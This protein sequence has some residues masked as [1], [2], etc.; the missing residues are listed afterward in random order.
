MNENLFTSCIYTIRHKD[1]L[2]A[3]YASGGTGEFSER[4]CWAKGSRILQEAR[5]NKQRVPVLFA[6][7]DAEIIDGVIYWALIDDSTLTTDDTTV[8]YS[9]LQ[10]LP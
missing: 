10:P 1:F 9:S 4:G 2:D 3:D 6:P 7:A 5:L 8:I